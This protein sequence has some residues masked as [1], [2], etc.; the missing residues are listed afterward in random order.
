M[1]Q[2]TGASIGR[3]TKVVGRIHGTGDLRVEGRCEGEVSLKGHLHVAQTGVVDAPVDAAELTVEGAVLGDVTSRGAVVL[4]S[5]GSIRG[6]I[7]AERVSL[8]DG[9]RFTGKIEMNVELP[10]ELTQQS[11]PAGRKG[12]RS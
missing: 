11:R 12:S 8:E 4:R 5:T 3:T 9:A 7:Q 6:A 2:D 1:K 10:D